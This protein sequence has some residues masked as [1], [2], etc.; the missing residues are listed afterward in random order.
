MKNNL[1]FLSLFI[2]ATSPILA[3][4]E[5]E[6]LR[7]E[8]FKH[9]QIGLLL[10]H[11]HMRA[12]EEIESKSRLSLP[13]FTLYYN[14]YFNETWSLGLHTDLVTE[15]FVAQSLGGGD[16]VE[17]ERPVAPAIMLGYKPVEHFTFL[18]GGGVDIDGEETLGLIR[19][20]T[21]YGLEIINEW[22]FVVAFGYDIRID[23]FDS[24]Q[25]GV[26]IAKKF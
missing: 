8:E 1:F 7:S 16:A 5:N 15:Q 4:E 23:A 26:G 24:F 11:T 14:Y 2:L 12:G 18:V 17:R 25:L 3:Q 22:E 20:D 10:G 21:E 13:S 19:L 9:H 6:E